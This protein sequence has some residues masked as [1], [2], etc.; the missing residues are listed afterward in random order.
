M[1]NHKALVQ[2]VFGSVASK[3][4]VMNDLMSAGLHRRW[5]RLFVDSISLNQGHVYLDLAAG[6]GDI[7]HLL[8]R[9]LA[10]RN[11]Q[12]RIIAMDPNEKMMQHGRAKLID[13]SVLK[14][15]EW[16]LGSAESI[17]L[18]SNSV[19]TVMIS[20]GLRNVSDRELALKE[21]YRILK[22]GGH[23]LC[24]EFSRVQTPFLKSLYSL[25]S[26]NLIPLMG[27]LV[28]DD[29]SAYQYLVDSI[30]S[31]PDQQTLKTMLNYAGFSSVSY[32]N[33]NNGVV[34]I[35]EGWKHND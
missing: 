11:I 20:F 24:L 17:P 22:P 23:F 1:E 15:I 31:F 28:A 21:I 18:E 13:S 34:A 16:I 12:S 27:R 33:L 14:G 29:K 32:R 3:Y 6:T 19:D 26:Q 5:K 4:D 9:R 2:K 7:S 30:R 8:L 10:E 35:H 25:Y